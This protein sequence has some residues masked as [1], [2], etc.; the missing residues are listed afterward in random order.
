[1]SEKLVGIIHNVPPSNGPHLQAS[2]DVMI[3]VDSV[4]YILKKLDYKTKRI[5]V[6]K[7]IKSFIE[8]VTGDRIDMVINLCE[9]IDEDPGFIG[10]P[11]AL[12]E[13]AGIPFSGSSSIAMMISTDKVLSKRLLKGRGIRT[14]DYL[15]YNAHGHFNASCLRFPVIVKPRCE[16]ASIGID[17]ESVFAT[18]EELKK[19]IKDFYDRFG[20]LIVEE[21]IEGREFNVSVFGYPEARVMP[22]AEIDFPEFP[23]S[24]YKI[25]GYRAKWE[26]QSFEHHHTERK[27][28]FAMPQY[29]LREME[30]IAA[31]CFSCFMLRDYGRVDMRMDK[32]GKIYVLEVN[33]NPCISPDAGFPA[34]LERAGIT[35]TEMIRLFTEFTNKRTP[36]C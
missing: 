30:R 33:A 3:Q 36:P 18:N 28:S 2:D 4:E 5:P 16:D 29:L 14:P 11:A 12:L 27:F 21:Y 17:Q 6:T 25:V 32:H 20:T 8:G 23:D 34:A 19:N 9:T 26:K 7:D 22:I 24:M 31:E 13:L 1:M 15:I 10:H 35:Y